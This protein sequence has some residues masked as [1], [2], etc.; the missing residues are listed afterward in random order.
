MLT[1]YYLEID[2]IKQE[3][4]QHC[5]KNWDEIRC[6]Y[7][8]ADFSGVTRSFT[9]QFEFVNEAYDLLMNL[10]LRDGVNSMAVLSL[11]T[12]TDR[13]EWEEKFNAPIDF[14]SLVWDNHVLKVNCIDNSLASLIKANKGTKY[15]FAIGKDIPIAD[16]M[17]YGRIPMVDELGYGVIG[18]SI[19]DSSAMKITVKGGIPSYEGDIS[20]ISRIPTYLLNDDNI[21]VNGKISYGDQTDDKDSYCLKAE[22]DV[23][24]NIR[25][26][27]ALDRVNAMRGVNFSIDIYRTGSN[28]TTRVLNLCSQSSM[29]SY[30]GEFNTPSDLPSLENV[31]VPFQ[32]AF[33]KSTDTIWE[34]HINEAQ[35]SNTPYIW[36]DTGRSFDDFMLDYN[37]QETKVNMNA[38]D[39]LWVGAT[40]SCLG[41]DWPSSFW[42]NIIKQNIEFTWA[43]MGETESIDIIS[44]KTLCEKI[45]NRICFGK[46]FVN[47]EFSSHDTRF[48]DTYIIA[49][50]SA[51]AINGAKIY[52][53]FTEFVD[54]MQTVF[55]YTYYL[56]SLQHNPFESIEVF[57]GQWTIGDDYDLVDEMCP[58]QNAGELSYIVN[59]HLFAVF[60]TNDGK[61][62]TKWPK[63]ADYNDWSAYNTADSKPR[64][65]KIY[66]QRYTEIR[67]WIDGTY[68]LQIYQ[69]TVE[70]IGMD[71]QTIHFIHR[72]EL[73]KENTEVRQVKNCREVSYYVDSDSVYSTV[74]IGYDKHD[75]D[76]FNGRDEFNFNNTYSTGHSVN[77]K[78]LSLISKYRADCYGIEFAVQKRGQDT[79]D[80]ESDN[81]VFF[82][83]T[84][85]ENGVLVPDRSIVIQNAISDLVFNGAFSPMACVFANAGFIGMQAKNLHLEF[86]SSFGNSNIVIGGIPMSADIDLNTPLMTCGRLSFTTDEVDEPPRENDIIE[87]KSGGIVYRGFIDEAVFKYAKN[88]AVKYKLIVKDIEL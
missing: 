3:I 16:S 26:G 71:N 49:A 67:Y 66:V 9:S 48:N 36:E 19:E 52:S 42:V 58:E 12:I 44:P 15:E 6:A 50:E 40:A 83:L 56:G 18:E 39:I 1:K 14:T 20:H 28:G 73:F 2:G 21:T 31:W 30:Q 68:G 43:G 69:G 81:D 75:Y 60:N 74:N 10:Y 64:Q 87:V 41:W 79:T 61:F 33:V 54:W 86:A 13:W 4:P 84:K 47:A 46:L 32:T 8:R 22:K 38:G 25:G 82:V 53:S 27:I 77:D 65:D 72:S 88:E 45:L 5:I 24:V 57:D 37:T 7:K 80:N 23:T 17:E 51:R 85:R 55:G 11:Y 35:S 29:V 76:G 62:Y 34:V 59:K 63:T 70:S 78:K